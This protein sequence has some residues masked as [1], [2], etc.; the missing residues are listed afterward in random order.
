MHTLVISHIDKSDPPLFKVQR[1]K[2]ADVKIADSVEVTPPVVYPVDGLPTSDL[3]AELRWYLE[4]FLRYPFPPE[5]DHAQRALDT[6]RNWGKEAFSALFGSM[7]GRDW[8]KDATRD[9]LE[10]LHLKISSDDPTILAWPWEALCDPES[11]FLS[12]G[13]RMERKLN[14]I[15]DPLALPES[16]PKDRVN[17]LL[18]TARPFEGDVHYRSISRPLVE[19]IADK[20]LAATVTVLRPPTFENLDEHLKEKPDFYHILHFD[21]H[22]GYCEAVESSSGTAGGWG[23]AS[24]SHRFQGPQG[25][26]VFEKE[27]GEPDLISADKLAV[28]LREHRMP[29][30]V[31]NACQSAMLDGNAEDAFASVAASLIKAGVRSV[32]A[33]AYSLYVSGAQEFLPAFYGELLSLGD[34]AQAARQGRKKMYLQPERVCARGTHPLQDWLVP[35]VYQQ[36]AMDFSF[37][38]SQ[39]S[40]AS[41]APQDSNAPQLPQEASD[42]ENPYG[43]IGRDGVILEIERAMQRPPAAIL[44]HGLGGIGKTTIARGLLHWLAHTNGLGRG[45]FWFSFNEIRSAEFVLNQMGAAINDPGFGPNFITLPTENKIEALT[46]AFRE[47]RFVIVWD[48]F[49]SA[50]GVEGAHSAAMLRPEDQQL[51]KTFLKKLRNG[52]TKVIITSRSEEEWLGTDN[53]FKLSLGG[54]EGEER[55]D[56]CRVILN[57]LGLSAKQDDPELAALMDQLVGHPL[58]MRAVLP[59]LEDQSPASLT[60]ALKANLADLGLKGEEIGEKL[61]ATLRFVEDSL[62]QELK[63]LLVPLALHERFVV[64]G[65]LE[66]MAEKEADPSLTRPKIDRFLAAL[67]SAGLVR[68]RGQGIHELHPA[69][70]G[71]LRSRE[72]DEASPEYREKWTLAFVKFMG[73]LADVFA[74]KQ[75]HEQRGVFHLHEANFHFALGETQRLGMDSDFAALTQSLA[76]FALHSRDFGYAEAMYEQY[77]DFKRKRGDL[78]GEAAACHQLGMIA[79]EQR[80]FEAAEKWYRKSLAIS[81]KQ[82]NEQNVAASCHE[83]GIIAQERGDFDAAEDWYRKSLVISEKLGYEQ[84]AASAYH[85]LGIIAW[86]RRDF[87][88]AEKWH[89]KSLAIFERHGNEQ[90]VASTY[91]NLGRIAHKRRD[92]EAAE[93]WYHKAL[94]IHERLG[95]KYWAAVD[96]HNLGRIAD[97]RGD[98]AAAE[99]LY[100][101][102]LSIFEKQGDEYGVAISYGQLGL[103]AEQRERYVDSVAWLLKSIAAFS[104]QRDQSGIQQGIDNIMVFYTR[105]AP[106]EQAKIEEKWR[107]VGFGDFPKEMAAEAAACLR[108]ALKGEG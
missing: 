35:V 22:G 66:Q 20:K 105:A 88:A 40:R 56:F 10:Q 39:S 96:Y 63:P 94:E 48:N 23:G 68:D 36:E 69:L 50:R 44:I 28:L 67:A 53:R 41:Q 72:Q 57:D 8:F 4:D 49:E 12:L 86:E 84:G 61:F 27:N 64:A 11:D 15:A 17:I 101:E 103:L 38:A 25:H 65:E 89:H 13:C 74:P 82:G 106:D 90:G 78:E 47:N 59:R 73:S 45:A 77:A 43:F 81:E 98:F 62:P 87:E 52:K 93:K 16:L 100:H 37:A 60:A 104:R 42:E 1:I 95:L 3:M 14:R 99:S 58:M 107:Q 33:M 97:E 34:L 91:N 75:L 29:A 71:F 18:V 5:T 2:G 21:G 80:D 19:L 102:A 108:S 9:G 30:V 6:L 51:L 55:W 31:L 92:F 70:T 54:L 46:Q 26:L 79:F 32:A 85:E 7:H 76:S 24:G 83:L